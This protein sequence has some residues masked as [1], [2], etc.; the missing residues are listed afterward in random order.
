MVAKELRISELRRTLTAGLLGVVAVA[1]GES[2][3]VLLRTDHGPGGGEGAVVPLAL[4]GLYAPLALAWSFGL[5]AGL[6]L[7][8]ERYR[9][10]AASDS[11]RRFFSSR[12]EGAAL[13]TSLLCGGAV[14]LVLALGLAFVAGRH[15]LARADAQA[16]S[17]TLTA[18]LLGAAAVG[19]F[20][21]RPLP[22][23]F[24]KGLVPL[25]RCRLA[26]GPVSPLPRL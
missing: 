13:R 2:M 15:L 4:L 11:L 17:L 21:W 9:P 25:D 6:A 14:A 1:L 3:W 20:A 7:L 8:P 16:A 12:E 22:G 18:A 26:P 10:A 5:G 24:A 19:V 23:L